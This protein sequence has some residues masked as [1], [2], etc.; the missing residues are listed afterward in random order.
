L[1]ICDARLAIKSVERSA[2]AHN[3]SSISLCCALSIDPL[4]L[5]DQPALQVQR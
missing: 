3:G 5:K 1:L 2:E 4:Q